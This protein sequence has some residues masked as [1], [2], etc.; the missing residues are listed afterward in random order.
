MLAR[1]CGS[2]PVYLQ[3]IGRVRRTGG[4]TDKRCLLLDLAGAVHEHGMPDED[5]EWRLDEGQRK[6][7]GD[8][9]ALSMCL[10]CGA[11]VRY[12]SRGAV[13][14]RC[15]APW[16]PAARVAV[17]S[18]QLVAAV[19]TSTPRERAAE[20]ARL[21]AIARERG[22]K[23]GWVGIRFRERFGFWPRRTAA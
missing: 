13:C 12:A 11:V 5:R 20:L 15:G 3:T 19:P 16:P 21:E 8:R 2:L 14:A 10:A 4:R 18:V 1:G 17:R 6:K 7:K 22:Y 9:E 23:P